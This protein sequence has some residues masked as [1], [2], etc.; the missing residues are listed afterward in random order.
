VATTYLTP[1]QDTIVSEIDIAAPPDRVFK[2]IAD[3]ETVRRRAPVLEVY[4]MDLRVGGRWHL[5][6][7]MPKARKGF[8]IIRHHGEVLELDPPRLLVFTWFANFHDDPNSRSVVRWELSPTKSG[9]HVKVTHSG[10]APEPA[11]RADYAGGWPG[12]LQEIK[13]FVE[14]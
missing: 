2:A 1:D 4:E 9:T 8:D 7:R 12:V 10:L 14:Q 11:A 5:E 13:D 3:P 6:C